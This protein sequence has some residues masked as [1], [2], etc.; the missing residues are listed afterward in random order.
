VFSLRGAM[1]P[2]TSI[3]QTKGRKRRAFLLPQVTWTR[4]AVYLVYYVSKEKRA[5]QGTADLDIA[6]RAPR[7]KKTEPPDFDLF[8]ESSYICLYLFET[9]MNP[10]PRPTQGRGRSRS[11]TAVPNLAPTYSPQNTRAELPTQHDAIHAPRYDALHQ[12]ASK[13]RGRGRKKVEVGRG[14]NRH[15]AVFCGI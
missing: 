1:F 14:P 15:V 4:R 6:V 3:M 5:A 7:S 12:S 8:G 10:R 9:R 11:P 13:V 2:A